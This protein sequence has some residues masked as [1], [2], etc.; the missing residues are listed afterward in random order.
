MSALRQRLV[1]GRVSGGL[2]CRYN[3]LLGGTDPS[4][5]HGG[6]AAQRVLTKAEAIRV[7]DEMN[8]VPVD[9]SPKVLF[10]CGVDPRRMSVVVFDR[11]GSGAVN[12]WLSDTGCQQLSNGLKS[13]S[14]VN[15]NDFGRVIRE[16]DAL[17]PPGRMA[18]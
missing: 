8:A 5:E 16:V 9:R 18:P 1:P 2:I 4:I 7:A 15:N 3:A 10:E 13:V 11:S 6:L 17:V 14:G 12:V